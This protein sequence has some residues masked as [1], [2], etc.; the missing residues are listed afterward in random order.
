[1]KSSQ[2]V[3]YNRNMFLKNHVQNLVEQLVPEHFFKN[4]W[5][6]SLSFHIV[7]FYC[8]SKSRTK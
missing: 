3:E 7:C 4:L 1:M 2:L 8:M 6:N 5:I